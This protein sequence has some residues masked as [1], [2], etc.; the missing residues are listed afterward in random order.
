VHR[1]PDL[2]KQR[3]RSRFEA[4]LL[5]S[6]ADDSHAAWGERKQA[7]IGA[8]RGTVV[9]LGP[10]TGVNM[11]YYASGTKVIAIEPNPVMHPLLKAAADEH[12]VDLEIRQ[13]G[14]A[15]VDVAGESADGVV[16]TLLL[17]GVDDPAQVLREAHRILKPGGTYFFIEHIASPAGSAN[18][19]VQGVLF[20]PHRWL[21]NGCE[22]TRDT[23]ATI[24]SGPFD[25]VEVDDVDR[26]HGALWV[27][28]QIVG[29]ATKATASLPAAER[30]NGDDC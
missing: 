2:T 16:G 6:G 24:R 21:F 18:R 15:A 19:R 14:G 5:E 20:R 10:G 26:G 25:A 22:I 7:V 17:C 3:R 11:R 12:G 1:V 9:E 13:L 23:E 8:M 30:A 29:T 27:R 4:R 28:H